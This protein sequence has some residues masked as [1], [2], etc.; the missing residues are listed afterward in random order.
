MNISTKKVI[1]ANT[2]K[3]NTNY[4]IM[5]FRCNLTIMI[6]FS[7][8][9]TPIVFSKKTLESCPWAKESAHSLR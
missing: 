9:E 2:K 4:T 3:L 6:E 5:T 8:N 7:S 1:E